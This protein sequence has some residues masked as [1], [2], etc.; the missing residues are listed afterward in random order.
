[1]KIAYIC[2]GNPYDKHSW[3]GTDYYTRQSLEDQGHEVYC[4]YGYK[5]RLPIAV[6]LKMIVAKLFGKI[7]SPVRN[8]QISD[9]WAQYIKQNIEKNTDA[10]FSIGTIPV[11]C[12]DT[13][14][15]I[16]ILVDGIFEQMRQ[17]YKWNDL[18]NQCIKDS[19]EIERLALKKCKKIISCSEETGKFIV[20]YYKIP[21]EKLAIVPLGAN[22]DCVPE[23]ESVFQSIMSRDKF[24]C[25]ILF[26]GIDW[27]RKGADIVLESVKLLHERGMNIVLHLCGLKNIPVELPPYVKN[28]GFLRKSDSKELN[29]LLALYRTSH[30][31][32]VPSLA[33]AY[34]LV[35]CEASAYG[36][37]SISHRL[38]GLTTIVE[39]GKNGQLFEKG[40]VPSVF[41]DYIE[42]TYN[43]VDKYIELSKNSRLRFEE[44]L[45]WSVAGKSMTKLMDRNK[46]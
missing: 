14:I 40:T 32:F 29:Q 38:G 25:N 36:L 9:Q 16:Y 18:S 46:I 6:I 43:D 17:F 44:L 20:D 31:L 35:F 27:E 11:A 8:K 13:E 39:N 22:L 5:P 33:E 42:R 15:P 21:K 41:A 3:S 34:G 28:H 10:I 45:N 2:T 7:Y 26:V 12:L 37:P 4:I 24:I 30:F 19:N 23:R 1:M